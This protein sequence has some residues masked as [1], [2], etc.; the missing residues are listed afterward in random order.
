MAQAA[1]PF[2]FNRRRK[3]ALRREYR[4]D[5]TSLV[6][7][8]LP[9]LGSQTVQY[10]LEIGALEVH[11]LRRD[12]PKGTAAAKGMNLHWAALVGMDGW[13]GYGRKR[14]EFTIQDQTIPMEFV[15][16][17]NTWPG[18]LQATEPLVVVI[19]ATH[20]YD[21]YRINLVLSQQEKGEPSQCGGVSGGD[22][23]SK[24]S[25]QW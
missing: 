12:T 21:Q 5:P 14:S 22:C 16:T 24:Q 4:P 11:W 9:R 17:I 15:Q 18:V 23:V 13:G 10:R 19:L 3:G 7:P 20:R 25:I 2:S 6:Q 8:A 1:L